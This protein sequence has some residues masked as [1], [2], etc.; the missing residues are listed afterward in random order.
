MDANDDRARLSQPSD[1]P[2]DGS[3][4]DGVD[5]RTA[6]AKLGLAAGA[7]YV[8]PL[9][10]PLSDAKAQGGPPWGRPSRPSRPSRPDHP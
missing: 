7:A 6:L 9:L 3:K 8:A 10:T 1:R 5:R 2:E 4:S